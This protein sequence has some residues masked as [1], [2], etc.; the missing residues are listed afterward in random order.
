MY[1]SGTLELLTKIENNV[2]G[3]LSIPIDNCVYF[4]CSAIRICP[5]GPGFYIS[6]FYLVSFVRPFQ[7]TTTSLLMCVLFLF[8]CFFLNLGCLFVFLSFM[9]LLT[10]I[11]FTFSWQQ[12]WI[13]WKSFDNNHTFYYEHRGSESVSE[14]CNRT[15]TKQNPTKSGMQ[16]RSQSFS[17][18]S[19]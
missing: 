12:I 17:I 14:S 5:G 13:S 4:V 3:F 7:Y 18:V 19:R 16:Q 11:H 10:F 6:H 9:L 2:C 15:K 8:V 1:M